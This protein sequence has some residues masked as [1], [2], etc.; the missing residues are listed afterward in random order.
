[1]ALTRACN[2]YVLQVALVQPFCQ[3]AA[4]S[5]EACLRVPQLDSPTA[6]LEP[7]HETVGAWAL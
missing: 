2:P 4:A 5:V 7:V 6:P 3:S 1:M